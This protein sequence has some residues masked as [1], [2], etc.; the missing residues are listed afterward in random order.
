[1][2][3]GCVAVLLYNFHSARKWAG[4]NCCVQG[5]DVDVG[6]VNEDD[7]RAAK[8]HSMVGPAVLV[9]SNRFFVN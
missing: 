1:M 4:L 2:M 8:C 5:R 3:T 6:G 9:C 7:P